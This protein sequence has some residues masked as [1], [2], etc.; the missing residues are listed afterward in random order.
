MTNRLPRL[1]YATQKIVSYA[2]EAGPFTADP[3]GWL[4]HVVV[5]NG[6]PFNT[7]QNAVSPNRRFSNLWVGKDGTVEQY[8]HP[9]MKPWA[10]AAGN[11]LYVAV[12]TEGFPE[13][14]LTDAQILSLA[15]IHNDLG[16]PDSIADAVGQVGV[17]THV[18]GGAAWGNHSCPGTVRAGQRPAV[19]AKAKSLR[20]TPK[21]L[22]S[23]L[24]TAFRKVVATVARIPTLQQGSSGAIVR[25]LQ[26]GLN[27][28][29]PSYSHLTVDGDFGPAT[30]AVVREF[31]RRSRLAADGVVGP[32]TRA[33]L[34]RC[35]VTY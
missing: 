29:F 8:T 18:M 32:N 4:L 35:G 2:D 9:G 3:L 26:A 34:K 19:I 25:R 20:A 24:P 12:E 30:A 15:K 11:P 7:F 14:P 28:V 1:P 13:E 33:A 31:Q 21:P 17:G 10:Q 22:A 16:A 27:R 23:A 5:G 6:S